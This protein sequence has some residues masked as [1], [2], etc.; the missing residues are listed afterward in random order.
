M[1]TAREHLDAAA[2]FIAVSPYV[3]PET[4]REHVVLVQEI[5]LDA[6]PV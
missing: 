1:Y 6:A 5:G 4:A 3:Q 2:S